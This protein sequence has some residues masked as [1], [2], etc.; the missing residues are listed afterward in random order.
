M[1]LGLQ[2]RHRL[3]VNYDAFVQLGRVALQ[4]G[5]CLWRVF[6]V[7]HQE[8]HV[9]VDKVIVSPFVTEA[10]APNL[11]G[12]IRVEIV[13][14]RQEEKRHFELSQVFVN[15][16]P[17]GSHL[18]FILAVALNQIA[19]VHNEL[20]VQQ[21][22]HLRRLGEDTGP[23]T[24]GVVGNDREL[25]LV[26]IVLEIEMGVRFRVLVDAKC[27]CFFVHLLSPFFYCLFLL[28]VS[29]PACL[30]FSWVLPSLLK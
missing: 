22:R 9:L 6:G 5:R 25:E 11:D 2:L 7:D 27:I 24:A 8:E 3:V 23:C 13:I 1:F 18:L 12:G 20:R 30:R 16:L 10:L 28:P 14:A 17:P 4:S 19:S 21:V 29:V 26:G 15:L